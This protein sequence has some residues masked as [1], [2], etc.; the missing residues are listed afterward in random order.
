MASFLFFQV[1]LDETKVDA[2]I[3][4][5]SSNDR[6]SFD[7][8]V[9]TLHQL[10]E[11]LATDKAIILVANKIDLARKRKIDIEGNQS[12]FIMFYKLMKTVF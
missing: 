3:V 6:N 12:H 5:F 4:V 1:D 7:V 10:R 2:Y 9:E 11:E 8:A